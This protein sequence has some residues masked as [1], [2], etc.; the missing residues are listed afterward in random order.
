MSSLVEKA[1]GF[2]KALSLQP[3]LEL[4]RL[5]QE[6]FSGSG[7]KEENATKIKNVTA[8]VEVSAPETTASNSVLL[9]TKKSLFSPQKHYPVL[10]REIGLD[11]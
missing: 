4:S 5:H 8:Q 2:S 9:K 3:T 1:E 6:I 10:R 7:V 11:T